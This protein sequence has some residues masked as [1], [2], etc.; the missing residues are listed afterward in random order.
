[1]IAAWAWQALERQGNR[2]E[3]E[4]LYLAVAAKTSSPLA[5]DAQFHLGAT[6]YA[7]GKFEAAIATF[8]A[9][10][11]RLAQ[12]RWRPTVRL[13]RGW[14]LV[15]LNRLAEAVP[16]FTSVV[17]DPQVGFQARYWLGLTQKA[18]KDYP[19]AARTLLAAAAQDP[20]GPLAATIR[21]HAG[22]A[23][24]RA[25]DTARAAEQ[26][27]EALAAAGADEA[28]A[29]DALH[30]KA[31]AALK[32][33][34]QAALERVT[35][36][37]A[38]RFPNSPLAVDMRRISARS[39]L[40]HKQFAPAAEIIKPMVDARPDGKGE[41]ELEDRYLLALAY[42]GMGRTQDA[43]RLVTPVLTALPGQLQANAQL[44][45][46][47][48]LVALNKHA[49]AIPSLEAFLATQPTGEPAI[50]CLG[51]LSICYAKT[52]Q[53]DKAK[54]FY[55]EL[56]QKHPASDVIV[57]VTAQMADAAFDAGDLEWSRRLFEWLNQ[58]APSRDVEANSLA[59]VGWTQFKA[60]QWKEAA[61]SFAAVLAKNPPPAL[62]VEM[63]LV[64]GK[65][66]EKLSSFDDALAMYGLV[67]D[68][69]PQSA[70]MPQ[71]LWAAAQVHDRLKQAQAAA[72]LYERLSKEYPQFPKIDE[73]LYWWAWALDDL[74]HKEQLTATFQR[75]LK[76]HPQSV[77]V[78]DA[79]YRLASRAYDQRDFSRAKE[80][81]GA[82][83]Q[84]KPT[85]EIRKNSLYLLGQ[86]AMEQQKYDESRQAFGTLLAEFSDADCRA[87]ALFGV[88]EAYYREQRFT[89]VIPRL[90]SLAHETAGRSEPWMASIH[91][92]LRAIAVA[93][94]AMERSL[95]CG[96]QDPETVPRI[97]R[98]VRGRLRDGLVAG[99]SGRVRASPRL[100]PQGTPQPGGRENGDG[101]QGPVHDR[102]DVLPSE[103]LAGSAARV[104]E[105]GDPLRLPLLAVDQPDPG[106]QVPRGAGRAERSH[107]AVSEGGR[108]IPQ[109]RTGRRGREAV[110]R[111]PAADG[112]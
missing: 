76:E 29:A 5:E 43:L 45:Q 64:R 31:Q 104:H 92:R 66:L 47:S 72:A 55:G 40:E 88:A 75:L 3:A 65:A 7:M 107:G 100:L 37:F 42:E 111:G 61:A 68:K 41:Q 22:D 93:E 79:T 87:K 57:P 1:M 71:A 44:A 97:C 32:A 34:D 46:G 89:E 2:D 28:L 85:A 36:D 69:Y 19:A 20:K 81:I 96:V 48:L 62:T 78:W 54:K 106:G 27:D 39:L 101:S 110:G 24:L 12:S 98:A 17:T 60:G 21:F 80:L 109:D 90:Q 14:A 16:V 9:F 103:E 6:Q 15:K 11:T 59:G 49:E 52:K 56:I 51:E 95:S 77:L 50:K 102:R 26:F 108:K 83:L 91:L 30:G 8:D 63:A 23:L 38:K 70:Q 86:I 105:G 84:G 74:G 10:E 112:R 53:V 82:V 58:S 25:G 4:R 67:I 18:Q 94:A 35:S 99:Q 33:K 13:G 73:V